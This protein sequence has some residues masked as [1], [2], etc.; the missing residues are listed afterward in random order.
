MIQAVR[1]MTAEG[2]ESTNR[3][4]RAL[5]DPKLS[6]AL[7]AIHK[8]PQADWKIADLARLAG[9]SRARFAERFTSAV[10]MPP[11]GY[12]TAWRLIK[13]RAMLTNTGLDMAEIASRCGYASVPS[14][15][16]RFK[17]AFDIG[18]GAYRRSAKSA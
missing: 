4:V 9:M 3:F 18:P 7:F 11:A 2:H 15:S 17:S 12:L 8:E 14:F 6:K 1:R 5:S 16:R 13:A 10:G